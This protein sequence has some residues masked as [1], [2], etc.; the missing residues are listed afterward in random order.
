MALEKAV[1]NK[2]K[3]IPERDICRNVCGDICREDIYERD[4]CK[5]DICEGEVHRGEIYEKNGNTRR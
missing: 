3:D 4:V 2:E 5:G 1:L